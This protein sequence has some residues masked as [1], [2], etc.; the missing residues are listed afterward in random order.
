M[1]MNI[2]WAGN[3]NISLSANIQ[4]SPIQFPPIAGCKNILF[5]GNLRVTLAPLINEVPLYGALQISFLDEPKV[6]VSN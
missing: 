1:D 3:S 2:V 4:N 5:E 6:N